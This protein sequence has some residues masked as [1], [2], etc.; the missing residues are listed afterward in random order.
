MTYKESE[1]VFLI[2]YPIDI[3][4]LKSKYR[5]KEE[6]VN[7]G[8]SKKGLYIS[9]KN[10][11]YH[12]STTCK[13]CDKWSKWDKPVYVNHNEK[14]KSLVSSFPLDIQF[15]NKSLL[16]FYTKSLKIEIESVKDRE[17]SVF[18]NTY[19]KLEPKYAIHIK[20]K[21][22]YNHLNIKEQNEISTFLSLINYS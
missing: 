9:E 17:K 8:L 6:I 15:V 21:T 5:S 2:V 20:S 22:H 18:P 4:K 11:W 10:K 19:N 16:I 13:S 3:S 14:T 7:Y 12:L 1:S